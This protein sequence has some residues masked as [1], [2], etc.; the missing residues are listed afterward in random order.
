MNVFELMRQTN[1]NELVFFEEPT[2]SLRAVVAVN[3]LTLGPAIATCRI[4]DIENTDL[5]VQNTLLMA[6]YNTYRAALL[7]KPFGGAGLTLCGHTQQVKNEMFFRALG[8]FINKLNGKFYLVRSSSITHQ[9]M[10]DIKRESD[11]LLGMNE[12]Y[13]MKGY[14]PVVAIAK[15]MIQ[16]FRAI[17]RKFLKQEVLDNLS[18]IVQ[19]VGEV[20]TALVRELLKLNDVSITI[21]DTVYDKIKIIQDIAPNVKVV[22]PQDIYK[23]KCDIFVS[24][25][26][27][28]LFNKE[29]V[30]QLNC[31]I[32]TSSSNEPLANDD[33]EEVLAENNIPYIPGFI[34]NGGELIYLENEFKDNPPEILEKQY[35]EIYYMASKL[36]E[37]AEEEGK[38]ITKLAKETATEY[39][40]NV[41]SIKKLK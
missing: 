39:I 22:K 25:G 33:V 41:A 4:Q 32:L 37:K 9:D 12:R 17:A 16:G 36:F 20:G 15:G 24:C 31:K 29:I 21:T 7:H 38:S 28:H 26:P 10:K 13:I 30:K 40:Q 2:V 27:N 1:N 19:G 8:V 34:I 3:D 11:Y 23:Q 18:F 35:E 14:T 6:L 5:G